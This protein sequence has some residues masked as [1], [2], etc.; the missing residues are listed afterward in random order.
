MQSFLRHFRAISSERGY[1]KEKH[2]TKVKVGRPVHK[3]WFSWQVRLILAL[4]IVNLTAQSI[5]S[6]AQAQTAPSYCSILYAIDNTGAA[7]SKIYTVDVTNANY[8]AATANSG[9]SATNTA[10]L[11]AAA[12]V[13]PS[14]G[15]VFYISR[16]TTGTKVAYWNPAT[17]ARYL[18]S[19]PQRV[20]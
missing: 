11:S 10:F 7:F 20:L 17:N 13:E 16:D 6:P 19:T 2:S 1:A 3:G 14:T 12:A 9:V 15:R 5:S 8:N 4:P 18:K